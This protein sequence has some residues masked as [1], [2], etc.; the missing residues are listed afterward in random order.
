M[1]PTCYEWMRKNWFIKGRRFTAESRNF[2]YHRPFQIQILNSFPETIVVMKARQLGISEVIL[3]KL[4]YFCLNT[5]RVLCV[6]AFPV[7]SKAYEFSKM[8]YEPA[9]TE[10]PILSR[11][12]N[13]E[14]WSVS[15]RGFKNRSFILFESAFSP[16]MGEARAVD[17]LVLDEYDRMKEESV[18]AFYESLS[19]SQYK[20]KWYVSTPTSELSGIY[21]QWKMGTRS[22]FFWKCE[23]CGEWQNI[24]YPKNINGDWDKFENLL[25]GKRQVIEELRFE[26]VC[27]R[28][29]RVLDLLNSKWEW[30]DEYPTATSSS[31]HI[32]QLDAPWISASEIMRKR[33]TMGDEAQWYNYVLGAPVKYS[34]TRSL[35]QKIIALASSIA[36]DEPKEVEGL[37]IAGIDWGNS[38]YVVILEKGKG[39]TIRLVDYFQV[40]VDDMNILGSI[41][42]LS[43]YLK[44]YDVKRVVVDF[45][46]GKDRAGI[47]KKYIGVPIV[48]MRYSNTSWGAFSEPVQSREIRWMYNV[49]R[50]YL[51][52]RVCES[53][54]NSRIIFP[55]VQKIKGLLGHFKNFI[56]VKNE[57]GEDEFDTVGEDHYIHA[58]GYALLGFE[59]WRGV[60]ENIVVDSVDI[61]GRE[62]VENP[63]DNFSPQRIL[64]MKE[65]PLG[66]ILFDVIG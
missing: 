10:N 5:P 48:M 51:L 2:L 64:E 49:G 65:K 8:R 55:H 9:I 21:V 18:N 46:Y 16:Y 11:E 59:I 26:K 52:R 50:Q 3:G 24:E 57:R 1:I 17:C 56:W 19:S 40:P 66:D 32:S 33:I 23:R 61:T 7:S 44:A 53:I 43:D 6:Y 15:I 45:G 29:G 13:S 39:E 36:F 37:R 14:T 20:F 54:L 30:V 62:E 25:S 63:W 41:K 42:K 28:C 22:R 4:T 27:R 31:F 12:I 34:S 60:E 38:N 58:F 47:L 35:E